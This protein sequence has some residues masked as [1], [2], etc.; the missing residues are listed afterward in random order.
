[1]KKILPVL[2]I[3][4]LCINCVACSTTKKEPENTIADYL[5]EFLDDFKDPE[6]VNVISATMNSVDGNLVKL[7]ISAKNS[8][9]GTVTSEHMLVINT[10]SYDNKQYSAG[11]MADEDDDGYYNF[12]FAY[13]YEKHKGQDTVTLDEMANKE[14]IELDVAYINKQLDKYKTSKGWNQIWPK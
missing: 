10:F 1:M 12:L 6:S 4:L 11:T 14:S 7:E 9:G 3:M 5:T 8:Y 2:L 13:I